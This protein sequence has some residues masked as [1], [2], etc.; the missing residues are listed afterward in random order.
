MASRE[1]QNP[2]WAEVKLG[3]IAFEVNERCD[4]NKHFPVLSMTKY[5]GF[6]PSQEYFGRQVYSRDLS[7]Y[8]V[9]RQGQFAYATIHLDEG[10]ID[11]LREYK[12]GLISPMYTV[13]TPDLEKVDP[14][15]LSYL[16]KS[17]QLVAKYGQLG[18]GTVN[19]RKSIGFNILSNMR[20]SIPSRQ[21]QERIVQVLLALDEAIEATR[22]VIEQIRRLK[23]TLLQNLLTDG[24]PGWH[25]KFKQSKYLGRIPNDWSE[26]CLGALL[27]EPIR[28]GY[29]PISPNLPT[30]HWVMTLSAVS[31]EGYQSTGVKP[32]PLEDPNVQAAV[33]KPGD[34]LVSRSNTREL[35]GLAGI[36][37]GKP[38]PCSYS[39][40]LMRVRVQQNKVIN[41]YTLLCL[42]SWRSRNYFAKTSRGTSG[43]MKKIDRQILESLPV[44]LPSLEEQNKIVRAI[45]S[46]GQRLESETE[47]LSQ[48]TLMKKT[49]GQGLLT[50]RIPVSTIGKEVP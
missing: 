22:A 1:K 12:A 39:D 34:I 5:N 25:N 9:V 45:E 32:A 20:F 35:V 41:E 27:L 28:N 29:S 17:E 33:A 2:S 38:S 40:L 44:P 47:H 50:G 46:I 42:L 24:L 21:D 26:T 3:D 14:E 10:A 43:S 36:Y 18:Q 19:R 7:N 37:D 6:V 4:T 16:L 23:V 48:L 31:L 15:F 11:L 13:F 49:L 8:K 30:G